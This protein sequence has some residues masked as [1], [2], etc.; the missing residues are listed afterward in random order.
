MLLCSL[1]DARGP[2][3]KDGKVQVWVLLLRIRYTQ[4]RSVDS[5]MA[6]VE[7][8]AM[9]SCDEDAISCIAHQLHPGSGR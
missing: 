4:C 7:T 2:Q 5:G 6:Q 8:A 1:L 9:D 3:E